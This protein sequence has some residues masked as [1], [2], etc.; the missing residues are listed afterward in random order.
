MPT[1][2]FVSGRVLMDTGQPV[3]EPVSVQLDCGLRVLQVI[4]TDL[5]GYFQFVLGQGPQSNA[6]YS[7]A[8]DEIMGP[9]L[10]M[11]GA[12]GMGGSGFGAPGFGNNLIGCELRVSVDGFQSSV[13]PITSPPDLETIDVGTFHLSRIAGVEG[14]AIS[15]TSM[16]VPSNARKEFQ[17]GEDDARN[18]KIKPATEHFEKAV[19]DYD[20]YAAAWNELGK[21]Y[22]AGHNLDKARQ[23]F[24]KAITADPK[25]IPPYVSLASIQIQAEEYEQAIDTAGKALALN[26]AVD[27][28]NYFQAFGYFKLDRLDDAERSAREVEKGPNQ[29]IPQVHALLADIFLEKQDFPSAAGEMRAYLKQSPKGPLAPEI[30]KKLGEMGVAADQNDPKSSPAHTKAASK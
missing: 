8:D 22:A 25:Y 29:T 18:N 6:D 16:L 15:V 12:N 11:N 30:K 14:S 20:N 28:A 17:K 10:G 7:A 23:A 24:A 2:L 13:R 1:P 9:G 19:A 5:K 27:L 26:S 21:V 4:R 3:P